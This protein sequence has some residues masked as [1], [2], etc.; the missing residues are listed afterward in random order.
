NNQA[1]CHTKSV[2]YFALYARV[3]DVLEKTIADFEVKLKKD[4][5]S[6]ARTN[7]N[8]ICNLELE[9]KKLREKDLRQKDAFEEGIY[10][11]AEYLT[12][13]AKTQEQIGKIQ[14][15]LYQARHAVIPIVDYQEKIMR[16]TDCV[17]AMRSIDI[18]AAEKNS[19]LKSCIERIDY[20]NT[21]ESK[22]GIGRYV[23][24]VFELELT[25]K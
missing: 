14:D 15:A 20:H 18:S 12:R 1:I 17:N 8:I 9:L 3:I 21:M 24:N 19:F 22:P 2:Q 10:T 23:E 13:N 16:F 7:Q 25:L 6:A 4:T 5:G 11:K